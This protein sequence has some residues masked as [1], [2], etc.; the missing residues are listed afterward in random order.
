MDIAL[1]KLSAKKLDSDAEVQYLLLNLF[2]LSVWYKEYDKH[3]LLQ[4][5]TTWFIV[6]H[7]FLFLKC[8]RYDVIKNG[9]HNWVAIGL[10]SDYK[11]SKPFLANVTNIIYLRGS[12]R[13]ILV[14]FFFIQVQIAHMCNG[15]FAPHSH[16][17]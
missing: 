2:S 9:S 11:V 10:I 6:P 7:A 16:L 8:P 17:K 5:K 1:L 13:Q 12:N 3:R 15:I 4:S 14:Y